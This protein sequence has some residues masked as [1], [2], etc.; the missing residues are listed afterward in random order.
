[1]RYDDEQ[2]VSWYEAAKAHP[3]PR[4]T[5]SFGVDERAGELRLGVKPEHD[6]VAVRSLCERFPPDAVVVVISNEHRYAY[7]PETDQDSQ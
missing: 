1:M 4:G 5:T 3:L 7:H 6:E 2:L